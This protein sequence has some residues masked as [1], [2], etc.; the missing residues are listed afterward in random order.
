[1]SQNKKF[2][3]TLVPEEAAETSRRFSMAMKKRNEDI[4]NGK[5]RVN[6]VKQYL[7]NEG[8]I[9]EKYGKQAINEMVSYTKALDAERVNARGIKNQAERKNKIFSAAQHIAQA[10]ETDRSIMQVVQEAKKKNLPN[11]DSRIYGKLIQLHRSGGDVTKTNFYQK[12]EKLVRGN[13]KEAQKRLNIINRMVGLPEVV[14]PSSSKTKAVSKPMAMQKELAKVEEVAKSSEAVKGVQEVTPVEGTVLA[15]PSN[16]TA[17]LRSVSEDATMEVSNETGINKEG[18]N[19][20]VRTT[21]TRGNRDLQSTYREIQGQQA[22]NEI[23]RN[24]KNGQKNKLGIVGVYPQLLDISN[25]VNDARQKRGLDS[26]E[27]EISEPTTF[28]RSQLEAQKTNPYKGYVDVKTEEDLA[29]CTLIKVKGANAGIAIKPDGD[30]VALHKDSTSNI[31]EIGTSLVMMAR[32]MG[33]L[34]MDNYG[35]VLTNFYEEAGFKPV[36]QV[37]FNDAYTDDKVLLDERPQ[38]YTMMVTDDTIEEVLE[39]YINDISVAS[40]RQELDTLPRFDKDSYDE[41]IKD[42]DKTLEAYIHSLSNRQ[43]EEK[44]KTT[45]K[46]QPPRKDDEGYAAVSNFIQGKSDIQS[47]ISKLREVAAHDDTTANGKVT[48]RRI[49]SG[50]EKGINKSTGEYTITP[51]TETAKKSLQETLER[52]RQLKENSANMQVW[53]FAKEAGAIS[54]S[55]HKLFDKYQDMSILWAIAT[56]DLRYQSPTN[57][58]IANLLKDKVVDVSAELAEKTLSVSPQFRKEALDWVNKSFNH[59]FKTLDTTVLNEIVFNV[60]AKTYDRLVNKYGSTEK[61]LEENPRDLGRLARLIAGSF[62]RSGYTSEGRTAA[63]LVSTNIYPYKKPVGLTRRHGDDYLPLIH[64]AKEYFDKVTR[65]KS[66]AERLAKEARQQKDITRIDDKAKADKSGVTINDTATFN[67]DMSGDASLP[68]RVTVKFAE[69]KT[70]SEAVARNLAEDAGVTLYFNPDEEYMELVSSNADTFVFHTKPALSYTDLSVKTLQANILKARVD[71]IKAALNMAPSNEISL[72]VDK[73]V[74]TNTLQ[75]ILNDAYGEGSYHIQEVV[76]DDGDSKTLYILTNETEFDEFI[77]E[78][79]DDESALFQR[80]KEE[81]KAESRSNWLSKEEVN[82]LAGVFQYENS[83]YALNAGESRKV[84]DALYYYTGKE[85]WNTVKRYLKKANYL[86]I[87]DLPSSTREN[88]KTATSLGKIFLKK[89][90][91]KNTSSAPIHELIHDVVTNVLTYGKENSA[92]KLYSLFNKVVDRGVEG[93]LYGLETEQTDGTNGG[94]TGGRNNYYSTNDGRLGSAEGGNSDN[95]GYR[96]GLYRHSGSTNRHENMGSELTNGT[97]DG[98]RQVLSS[99]D[100]VRTSMERNSM[101]QSVQHEPVYREEGTLR[102]RTGLLDG[103]RT[104]GRTPR[105][106]RSARNY[107]AKVQEKDIYPQDNGKPSKAYRKLN[108][109]IK[110]ALQSDSLTMTKKIQKAAMWLQAASDID[111]KFGNT[112]HSLFP[113]LMQDKLILHEVLAY[114]SHTVLTKDEVSLLISAGTRTMEADA[115][116]EVPKREE[117]QMVLFTIRANSWK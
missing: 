80:G 112:D 63:T 69:G 95:S 71:A 70:P 43:K 42:R 19:N 103:R 114:G 28:Y 87:S 93:G 55:L 8:I 96:D 54:N 105:G 74:S 61:L 90:E 38:V 66:E 106:W 65:E 10:M 37:D 35:L 109:E 13:N 24:S 111:R 47:T 108:K 64:L 33:G 34:K 52:A 25:K 39:R 23:N 22:S 94:T 27:V 40:T 82:E 97:D 5:Q 100:R 67:V 101:A 75:A 86:T 104:S 17:K 57:P 60:M 45:T 58:H 7:A 31:Q 53:K 4:R 26:F 84:L 11:L 81:G 9:E 76:S 29:G 88:A 30:I 2:F 62:P 102:G 59:R 51:M 49:A 83:D 36:N 79:L 91:I 20:N 12:L 15:T 6:N 56:L 113:K 98:S 18:E 21:D 3:D 48:L 32:E 1:M 73:K 72:I 115:R 68:I 116:L 99:T 44:P 89:G 77:Q 41:A 107:V 14:S 117:N 16:M 50:L 92:K 46:R 110:R 85:N 78:E